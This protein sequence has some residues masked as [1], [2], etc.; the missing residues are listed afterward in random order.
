MPSRIKTERR[1][2][3]V[4]EGLWIKCPS[5][6]AVLYRAELERNVYV[7]PK[8]SHHMRINAR[9]RLELFLDE[10]SGHIVLGCAVC[11]AHQHVGAV[12]AFVDEGERG[13]HG[14]LEP[15]WEMVV[16]ERGLSS[17]NP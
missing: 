13:A 15:G 6:D 14:L 2:R 1:T 7:C 9:E 11:E 8:C 4:P 3:S 12:G 16:D 10:G 5:C 17:S